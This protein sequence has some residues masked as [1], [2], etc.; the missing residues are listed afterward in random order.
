MGLDA[1]VDG[2][3]AMLTEGEG[4]G[5]GDVP[6][7]GVK[8]AEDFKF[9]S[10]Q[11][12]SADFQQRSVEVVEF[13]SRPAKRARLLN[14]KSN[15]A[16]ES[17]AC[18][19]F[20]SRLARDSFIEKKVA[21]VIQMLQTYQADEP[22]S[23]SDSGITNELRARIAGMKVVGCVEASEYDEKKGNM[24]AS[25]AQDDVKT[26]FIDSEGVERNAASTMIQQDLG[27]TASTSSDEGVF[28]IKMRSPTS[29]Q[30]LHG[31]KLGMDQEE[32][33]NCSVAATRII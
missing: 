8:T 18:N 31:P 6:L 16:K 13:G 23:D 28:V 9:Y 25:A 7:D 27:D 3:S 33:H 20:A 15:P 12:C 24:K 21:N 11:T 4:E 22:M 14:D 29:K 17:Q 2:N 32:L 26:V 1:P 19:S 10:T 30:L 5:E